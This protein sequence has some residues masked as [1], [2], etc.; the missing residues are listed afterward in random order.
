LTGTLELL[1]GLP[2][3]LASAISSKIALASLSKGSLVKISPENEENLL[4]VSWNLEGRNLKTN[5]L[6]EKTLF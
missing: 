6:Q 2:R 4:F 1:G 3:S 5:I